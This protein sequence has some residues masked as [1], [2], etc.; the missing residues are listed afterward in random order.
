A[1]RRTAEKR[2]ELLKD[3]E[4]L[5]DFQ[6][7][8]RLSDALPSWVRAQGGV[9]QKGVNEGRRPAPE[10][11]RRLISNQRSGRREVKSQIQP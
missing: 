2:Q 3:L 9:F 5:I 6:L 4:A 8:E 11:P 10:R 1:M 7:E